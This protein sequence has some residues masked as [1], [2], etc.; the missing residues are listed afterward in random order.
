MIWKSV[1]IYHN[2]ILLFG[3]LYSHHYNV[4]IELHI[5]LVVLL[6]GELALHFALYYYA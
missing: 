1:I 4:L 6:E 3:P 5:V 2:I